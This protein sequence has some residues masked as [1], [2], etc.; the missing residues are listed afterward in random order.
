[1]DQ[2]EIILRKAPPPIESVDLVP[3]RQQATFSGAIRLSASMAGF[4]YDHQIYKPL[5]IDAGHWTRICNGT[6]NFPMDKLYDFMDLCGNDVPLIWLAERRKYSLKR[7]LS[8]VERENVTLRGEIDRLNTKLD[9]MIE[10]T[11]LRSKH[12]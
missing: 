5:D 7:R 8:D 12:D 3:I 6:A 9:H 10:F 2:Q 11:T 4:K 1:M